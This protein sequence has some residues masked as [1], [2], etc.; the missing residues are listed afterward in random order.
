MCHVC[1]IGESDP[2]VAHLL[3]RFAEEIGLA[4]QWTTASQDLLELVRQRQP[5]VIIFDPE[6]PGQLRGWEAAKLLKG[7]AG[8]QDIPLVACSW[9]SEADVRA[10]VGLACG[11][12][13]KPDLH[14]REFVATLQAAGI[15][16]R[17]AAKLT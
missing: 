11:Y 6:L 5:A 10:V 2:F 9:R 15:A 1:V 17:D 4:P 13:H 3:Q 12:L 8:T 16:P 7:N 14:V